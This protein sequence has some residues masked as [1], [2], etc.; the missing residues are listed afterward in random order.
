MSLDAILDAIRQAGAASV[1]AIEERAREEVARI[2]AEADREAKTIEQQTR[3]TASITMAA[4]QARIIHRA[5]LEGVHI[6]GNA[7]QKVVAL[8]LERAAA[9]LGELRST[10]DY[11]ELLRQLVV[12]ALAALQGSLGENERISLHADPRDRALLDDLLQGVRRE[13]SVSYELESWGG[14]RATSAE[15]RVVVDNTLESRLAL[16]TPYLQRWLPTLLRHNPGNEA[17]LQ[18]VGCQSSKL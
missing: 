9:R 16:A 4:D 6:V 7:E 2:M 5:R 11:P 1:H 15:Q 10:P 13:L 14:V 17:A 8:A 3:K 12:E 18:Q